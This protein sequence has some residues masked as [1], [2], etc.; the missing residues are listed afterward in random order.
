MDLLKNALVPVG[1]I[2]A[3][4]ALAS[5]TSLG[6][7]LSE[8]LGHVGAVRHRKQVARQGR[9]LGRQTSAHHAHAARLSR[10]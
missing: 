3:L 5:M 9:L 10:M 8:L 4:L 2:I 6:P 7:R 1:A